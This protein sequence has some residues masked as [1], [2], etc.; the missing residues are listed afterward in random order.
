M[1]RTRIVPTQPILPLHR[2][3]IEFLFELFESV[4]NSYIK[5][6]LLFFFWLMKR[7]DHQKAM[8]F[9]KLRIR[10]LDGIYFETCSLCF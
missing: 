10:K 6:D 9:L 7:K 8:I 4:H 1:D 5:S 3:T 2:I